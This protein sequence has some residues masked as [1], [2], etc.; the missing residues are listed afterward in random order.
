[1]AHRPAGEA[2]VRAG[3]I[4][5]SCIALGGIPVPVGTLNSR[6]DIHF[7]FTDHGRIMKAG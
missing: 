4:A 2:L 1:M 7:S 6:G 3:W 5:L